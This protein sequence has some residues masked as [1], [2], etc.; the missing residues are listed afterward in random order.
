ME[1][2]EQGMEQVLEVKKE[3]AIRVKCPFCGFVRQICKP[4]Q[5]VARCLNPDCKTRSGK[6]T[7]FWILR[8]IVKDG[9]VCEKRINTEN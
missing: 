7:V 2:I 9:V 6:Q 4:T 5:V 8:R 3:Q 1:G